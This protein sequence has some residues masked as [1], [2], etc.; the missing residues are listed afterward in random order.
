MHK[1]S[2]R[3][4][5][6]AAIL[7]CTFLFLLQLPLFLLKGASS[8][9]LLPLF[10]FLYALLPHLKGDAT[11]GQSLM[12]L[13]VLRENGEKL[14]WSDALRRALWL[15]FSTL[16]F[17]AGHLF[18]LFR[19]DGRTLQ[20]IESG[21][22]VLRKHEPYTASPRII[23]TGEY[24]G[25][26]TFEICE[27]GITIG[28]ASRCD[29]VFPPV[30]GISRRHCRV[31]YDP[32]RRRFLLTDLRSTFGT[33]TTKRKLPSGA[34]VSLRPG[35]CFWL[36]KPSY[37]FRVALGHPSAAVSSGK[38]QNDSKRNLIS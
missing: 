11:P 20:D 6:R 30:A 38:I 33:F 17:G 2:L 21:T 1:A 8:L 3:R 24:L 28:R 16:I 15:T 35:E 19:R 25:G 13:H 9:F 12:G 10:L 18:P 31:R 22:R 5:M 7:D 29:A 26:R 36:T 27:E 23:G 32:Q 34:T 14:R 4:R 37:S